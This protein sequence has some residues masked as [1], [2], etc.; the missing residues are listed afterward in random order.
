MNAPDQDNT[1]LS[2][3]KP[4][5][6]QTGTFAGTRIQPELLKLFDEWRPEQPDVPTRSKA[7]RRFAEQA[8]RR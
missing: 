4:R 1:R 6:K 2:K 7:L 3:R 8:L 5:P